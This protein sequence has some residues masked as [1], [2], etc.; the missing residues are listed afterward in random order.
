MKH[1]VYLIEQGS[2]VSR[3]G[4]RLLITKDGETLERLATLQVSQVVIF[5]DIQVTTPAIQLLLQEGIEVVFLSQK[6]RFY[7]R[8]VGEFAGNSPLRVAQ[9]VAS[10]DEGF[11]LRLAG[12][13]VRG[14]LHNMKVFLQRYARRRDDASARVAAEEIDRLTHG[15][16]AAATTQSL[17]GIEGRATAVY[18]SAWPRLLKSPWAFTKRQRR[19]PP[20]PVNALISFAYTLL[21]QN[22]SGALMTVGLDPYVGFLHRL[23]YNRPSLTLDM[24][25]EFRPLVADS[26]ALRCL[27]NEIL[28]PAHFRQGRERPSELTTEGL[29]L[30][31]RE[32]ERHLTRKFRHASS[33]DQIHFRRLFQLQAYDLAR[34]IKDRNIGCLYTPYQVR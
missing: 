32:F 27:N 16:G 33:G 34:A 10:Q 21:A 11:A 6:G 14:K 31:I 24:V 4:R 19:P 29:R 30:F 15:I 9:A 1:P 5:G 12:Q 8:L 20:D 7:G 23:E 26:V 22:V 2:K 3:Q 25:E 13:F 18:F 28:T 17:M